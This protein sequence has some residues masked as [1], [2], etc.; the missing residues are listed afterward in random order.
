MTPSSTR[1]EY[2]KKVPT[3]KCTNNTG[4]GYN[5]PLRGAQAYVLS[6]GA[7]TG[8]APVPSCW[9]FRWPRRGAQTSL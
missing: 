8:T 3:L 4:A 7:A 2:I 1:G 5:P 9:P 6:A